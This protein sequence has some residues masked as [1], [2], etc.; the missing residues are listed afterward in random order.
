L[1]LRMALMAGLLAIAAPHLYANTFIE[2]QRLAVDFKRI[3]WA[4]GG[5]CCLFIGL[6]SLYFS[7]SQI[8]AGVA[9]AIFFIYPAI[10]LLLAWRFLRQRPGLYL[11][12]LIPLIFCG[13]VLTTS[14]R[15]TGAK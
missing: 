4:I 7:L 13:I 8:A 2:I 3:G 6:T 14:G 15:A 12:C 10:T 5:G 9:I 1:A 11:L